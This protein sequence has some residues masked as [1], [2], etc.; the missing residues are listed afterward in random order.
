MHGKARIIHHDNF[1]FEG[2]VVDDGIRTGYGT[3]IT[4]K[5]KLRYEGEFKD[6]KYHG[7]GRLINLSDNT[8]VYSGMFTD[9]HQDFSVNF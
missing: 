7:K 1:I 4:I 3:E 2:E 6:G 9:G 5:A 8:V